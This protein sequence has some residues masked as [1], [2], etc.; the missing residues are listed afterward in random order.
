ML[1]GW[2][3]KK[4]PLTEKAPIHQE[5]AMEQ[6]REQIMNMGKSRVIPSN[7]YG[8]EIQ[9]HK[10]DCSVCKIQIDEIIFRIGIKNEKHA[11]FISVAD[12]FPEDK[13][14]TFADDMVIIKMQPGRVNEFIEY[15]EENGF[16]LDEQEKSGILDSIKSMIGI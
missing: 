14:I 2:F 6:N 9:E 11:N 13:K 7:P 10:N 15:I 5:V 16:S 8:N 4:N 1:K 3:E 12:N